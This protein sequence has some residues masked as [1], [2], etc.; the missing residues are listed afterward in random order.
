M[1]VQMALFRYAHPAE[2]ETSEGRAT[3]TVT[4]PTL[5]IKSE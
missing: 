2:D 4:I 3:N 5:I 1:M